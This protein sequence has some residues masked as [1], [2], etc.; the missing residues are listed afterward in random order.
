MPWGFSIK[1]YKV[2]CWLSQLE[3]SNR[4]SAVFQNQIERIIKIIKRSYKLE[5][6]NKLF[7]VIIQPEYI[8][9]YESIYL[10][11][12]PLYSDTLF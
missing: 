1:I 9:F 6:P 4:L 11:F 2:I 10:V 3:S 12:F 7:Q 8:E 5:E